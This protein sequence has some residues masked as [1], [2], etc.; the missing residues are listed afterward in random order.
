MPNAS[1][2][3]MLL[4]ILACGIGGCATFVQVPAWRGP[5]GD[6]NLQNMVHVAVPDFVG[7]RGDS[8]GAKFAD[9]MAQSGYFVLVPREH[10]EPVW[11]E[12][13]PG[14]SPAEAAVELGR[15]LNLDGVVLG[16]MVKVECNDRDTSWVL[17]DGNSDGPIIK[18]DGDF[19]RQ[20][21]VTVQVQ[22]LDVRSGQLRGSER[23]SR[24]RNRT[25]SSMRELRPRE[26]LLDELLAQV[27]EELVPRF[28]PH[29]QPLN[30]QL[31][32][33]QWWEPGAPAM[34]RGNA[35]AEQGNWPAAEEAWQQALQQNPNHRAA[36]YNLA[37][38]RAARQDF[39][40]AEQLLGQVGNQT[41]QAALTQVRWAHQNHQQLQQQRS[42][43]LQP[44]PQMPPA[45]VAARPPTR[46]MNQPFQPPF[47]P[48][49][50]PPN[51][52]NRFPR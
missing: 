9:R 18:T 13:R 26:Q 16:E 30:V 29:P 23:A 40:S 42:S 50:F 6:V 15:R 7:P 38:A 34:R 14:R 31:A 41:A 48:Q 5:T 35:L 52:D 33:A 1:L 22:L 32:P 20:A 3:M 46:P 4:A 45:H 21:E 47:A 2:R 49:G 28:A 17:Y 8:F 11:R 44:A 43:R 25:V 10:W 12:V 37:L 36:Q 39:A 51:P 24:K 27:L 19:E